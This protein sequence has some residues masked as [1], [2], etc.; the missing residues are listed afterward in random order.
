MCSTTLAELRAAVA[1]R[2][3]GRLVLSVRH[4]TLHAAGRLLLWALAA[5]LL[6]RQLVRL[7]RRHGWGWEEHGASRRSVVRRDRS[8]GGRE[9]TIDRTRSASASGSLS[10]AG[11]SSSRRP[12]VLSF[13]SSPTEVNPLDA[14]EV[15]RNEKLLKQAER[16][17]GGA[18]AAKAAARAQQLVASCKWWPGFD[19]VPDNSGVPASYREDAKRQAQ[20][21]LNWMLDG[22][23]EGQDF[24]EDDIVELRNLCKRAGV[25]VALGTTNTRESLFRSAI[26][27]ALAACSRKSALGPGMSAKNAP[28]VVGGLAGCIGMEAPRAITMV[29]AAVASQTRLDFLQ[30]LVLLKQGKE[31]DAD[32]VMMKLASILAV[33]TPALDSPEME[34]VM[35]GLSSKLPLEERRKLLRLFVRA[36]GDKNREIAAYALGLD[37]EESAAEKSSGGSAAE[38]ASERSW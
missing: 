28:G 30:A 13:R 4:G 11:A 36:G 34:L 20:S 25:A 5:L 37:P 19:A 3:E 38:G 17:A 22:R 12:Q 33:F 24:R 29:N 18:A 2:P 9:V 15:M 27:Y 23:L 8:L 32:L 10:G 21:K 31:A 26:K 1:V 16:E 35:S 6:G 14:V 7:A